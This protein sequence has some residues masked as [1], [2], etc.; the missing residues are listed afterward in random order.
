MVVLVP[1]HNVLILQSGKIPMVMAVLGIE[2]TPMVVAIS[3]M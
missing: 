1:I 3:E 2:I